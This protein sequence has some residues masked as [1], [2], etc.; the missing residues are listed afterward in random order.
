MASRSG[1]RVQPGEATLCRNRADRALDV[2]VGG[3][4][5]L[6]LADVIGGSSTL[7]MKESGLLNSNSFVRIGWGW[8]GSR[9]TGH[10]VFR[11]SIGNRDALIHFQ[12][13]LFQ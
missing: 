5:V 4:F 7:F 2:L 9:A 10:N 3:K 1:D 11:I 8:V 12:W 13:D 6:K